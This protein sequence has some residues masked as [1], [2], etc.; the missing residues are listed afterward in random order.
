[1]QY[2]VWSCDAKSAVR[3][4]S[5]STVQQCWVKSADTRSSWIDMCSVFTRCKLKH[6]D[7]R[8]VSFFFN[9]KCIHVHNLSADWNAKRA[10]KWFF[11]KITRRSGGWCSKRVPE[12]WLKRFFLTSDPASYCFTTF[13]HKL[14]VSNLLQNTE[15]SRCWRQDESSQAI[16]LSGWLAG[17]Q[18]SARRQIV[19]GF[20]ELRLNKSLWLYRRMPSS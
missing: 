20:S 1:M 8:K 16:R 11:P 14:F 2:V 4:S 7:R 10:D 6:G 9:G 17:C 15:R 3:G 12:D 19:P 18:T 13:G 5:P